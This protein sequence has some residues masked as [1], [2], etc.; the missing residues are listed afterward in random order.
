MIDSLYSLIAK[1][2]F[3]DP[4]HAPI[5]HIP[6]G[7]VVGAFVFLLVA[8]IFGR[9]NLVT[10][11]RHVSILA[12]I[13]VFPTILFGVLDWLHFF[14][15]VLI[16]PIRYK[17]ILASAVLVILAVGIFVGGRVRIQ[18]GP[19]VVLYALAFVCVVGLGW[20]GGRL[21][22]GGWAPQAPA[23]TAP[24]AAAPAATAPAATAPAGGAPKAG[25]TGA[26]ATPAAGATSAAAVARGQQLFTDNCT[27]CHPNG[28]NVVE[29]T[30]PL[31]SSKKLASL[32]DLTAFVRSPHMP[33]GSA[34]NMPAFAADQ[35]SDAQVGD[36]YAYVKSMV[37]VWK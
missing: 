28:G 19:M 30:L 27:A 7:L 15:G 25:T 22:Y 2:G 5:T 17:I 1:T 20:F 29:A 14:K 21:V 11:A 9:R 12:F 16:Q 33:D 26:A 23:A 4:L 24:A 3:T 8:V 6:I 36:I 32:A 37:P 18:S 13:F 34:G 35:L 31:K 10:T